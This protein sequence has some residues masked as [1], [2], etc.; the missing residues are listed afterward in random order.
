MR[1]LR[2]L[3]PGAVLSLG[4]VAAV[5]TWAYWPTFCDLF[6]VWGRDPQYSHGYLVPIFAAVLLWLRRPL[7]LAGERTP[8][9]WGLAPLLAGIATRLAGG[10]FYVPWLDA[11]SLL[12]VLSGVA[13]LWGGTRAWRWSWPAIAFMAFMVPLPYRI[14]IALG[15]PL[16]HWATVASTYMLQ[17][18]GQPAVAEG[19]TILL[20]DVTLGI[21]EACSG[22]RMLV[23]F[24]ALSTA[25]ALLAQRPVWEK[26][27]ILV[28]AIPIALVTNVARITATGLLHEYAGSDIANAVFHD[29][30]GWLMMP[31]ALA[32]LGLELWVLSRLLIAPEPMTAVGPA[33]WGPP[34]PAR[35]G[36]RRPRPA[37]RPAEVAVLAPK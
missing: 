12:V 8:T 13:L 10:F 24:F 36:V 5:L 18:L 34:K 27:L 11:M 25:V 16:Q 28:S 2:L 33:T 31:F 29:L 22:L 9:W 19:N 32:L 15:G 35:Q 30:A 23:V 4:S 20:K 14:E 1:L 17:T 26:L 6:R 7:L 21:V 3:S 37:P